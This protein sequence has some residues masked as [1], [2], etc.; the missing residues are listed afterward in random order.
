M[1]SVLIATQNDE[2]GLA[3]TLAA[4]V[5]AAVEGVVREVIVC[6]AG[7]D[8]GTE[9]V[10]DHAGCV[11]LANARWVDGVQLARS[12]WLLF[13]EP[14]AR[15]LPDWT[16]P[17]VTHVVSR[18][19]AATFTRAEEARLTFLQ[20]LRARRPLEEGLLMPKA[21][22]VS[23]NCDAEAFR[24]KGGLRRLGARIVPSSPQN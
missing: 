20:R 5:S 22:F 23:S 2:E 8:D 19:G 4:L 15:L 21:D 6:D 9:L 11:F 7:S 18:G 13:L 12:A 24:G 16:E 17:V 10:A 3:G 1:I 14:G